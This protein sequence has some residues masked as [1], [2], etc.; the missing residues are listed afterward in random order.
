MLSDSLQSLEALVLSVRDRSSARLAEE[1]INAYH[2]GAFRAAILSI[3]VAVCADIISKLRELATGGDAAAE[4]DIKRLQGWIERHELKSLQ[5]FENSLIEVARDKFQML[6]GHEATAL[7]RLR[8]D[9][10]LC[11]HPAFVSDEEFFTP[12]AE[13]TRSHIKHAIL[14]LLSRA[15]VQGKQ[16]IE[17]F[18]RDLLGGSLPIKRDEIELV[19]RQNYLASARPASV[20]NLIKALAKSLVGSE[21]YAYKGKE[22]RIAMALAA[23]GRIAPGV[24]E[25]DLPPVIERLGVELGDSAILSM[26]YYIGEESRIWEWL[27]HA[28]QA[29]ILAKIDSAPLSEVRVALTAR[30][31]ETIGARLLTRLKAE[32]TSTLEE[33][34]QIAPARAFIEEVLSLYGASTNY[35]MA[36]ARGTQLLVPHA[37]YLHQSDI[38]SLDRLIQE[39]RYNQIVHASQ[40]AAVL[41]QVFDRTRHLLPD[42]APHWEAIAAYIGK[43]NAANT[44]EYPRFFEMLEKAGIPTPKPPKEIEDNDIPF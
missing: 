26:C 32:G 11:A 17:R 19:L 41:S 18:D 37:Q 6:F 25:S 2:A 39:N 15:P 24:Y 28:G 4:K 23:L 33:I 30:H 27:G 43:K 12:T 16:L 5:Q 8:D 21:A 10:H 14:Y 42:S 44:Y 20:V 22:E 31:I 38:E 9:R 1:A 7:V 40:T 3:W 35:R 13:L 36:E 34:L 29:R